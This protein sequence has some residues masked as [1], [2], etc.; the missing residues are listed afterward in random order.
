M[1]AMTT[2]TTT[3]T[4]DP[5]RPLLGLLRAEFAFLRRELGL[6]PPRTDAGRVSASLRAEVMSRDGH[7]CLRCQA[8][9]GLELDHVRAWVLGGRTTP[10]NLQV[11]C[12]P[13]N[14]GKGT[15]YEDYRYE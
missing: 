3:R 14:R 13:C 2:A 5:R 7:R 11:L 6:L 10:R 4:Q 1:T 9:T 12:G 15:L 8:A